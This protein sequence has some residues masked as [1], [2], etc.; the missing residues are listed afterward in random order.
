MKVEI[1]GKRL[2]NNNKMS[3][4]YRNFERS[5]HDLSRPVRTTMSPG[6]LVPICV[7]PTLN[8][9][10]FDIDI[11]SIIR[12]MPT[13]GP[14]FGSFKL[15][16]DVFSVPMRLYNAELHMNLS[17]IGNH[18]DRVHFPKIK[19]TGYNPVLDPTGKKGQFRQNTL[20]AYLGVRGMNTPSEEVSQ[21]EMNKKCR[22]IPCILGHS[23]TILL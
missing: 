16:V 19:I 15:Q 20:M 12:T 3:V 21:Y 13:V 7:E 14:L 6:T 4:E 5:T 8:G 11:D 23:K 18:M 22:S 10:T 1:G 2:G 17:G 9:D